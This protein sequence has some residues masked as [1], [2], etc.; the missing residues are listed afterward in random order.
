MAIKR[1]I[2]IEYT[3]THNLNFKHFTGEK[4]KQNY[5]AWKWKFNSKIS[6]VVYKSIIYLKVI[7]YKL[8]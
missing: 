2:V 6:W 3:W 4:K 7:S 1:Y 5:S 8:I